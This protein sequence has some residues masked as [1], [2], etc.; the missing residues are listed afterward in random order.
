MLLENNSFPT[1]IRPRREAAAL[2]GDGW[3]VSCISPR[4]SNTHSWQGVF[5]GV[6]VY[7]FPA[8]PELG[9]FLGY[10]V[11][12]GY[13]TFMMTLLTM[14]VLVRHGFD[15][16]HVHNPPDTFF[17][18]G[19]LVRLLGKKFIF[20]HHD[21]SP[22]M[23]DARNEN[24]TGRKDGRPGNPIVRQVLVW[25]EVLTL[26]A[27]NLIIATNGSYKQLEIER[28][29]VPEDRIHIVRNGPDLA[30]FHPVAPD[31]DLR[32]K[33]KTLLGYVGIM[34][35]QD[36]VDYALRALAHLRYTLGREDF[37]AVFIGKGE[38]LAELKK[39]VVELKLEQHVL[40]TGRIAYADL[41][42]YLS[43]VDICLGPDPGNPF[44][45]RS[46]MIKMLEY[47]ALHKPMVAFD[48]VEHRVSAGEAALYAPANDEAA[49]AGLI[50]T[51]MDDPAQRV[52]MGEAGYDRI[53]S[54]LAWPFQAERLLEAYHLLGVHAPQPKPYPQGLRSD[55][56]DPKVP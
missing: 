33:A 21:L 39:L 6:T 31:P 52:R 35:P 2:L 1:D 30:T 44:T 41:L 22:E 12:Y 19:A 55:L 50:Q 45:T 9:G 51:L 24:G 14:W 27:A 11:E 28:S 46:T 43:T 18:L 29:G 23:Y 42:R 16:L 49:M 7:Y 48:L 10:L 3:R 26:R 13:A 40:F 25:C 47:M 32:A 37:F 20:D 54:G 15:V 34:G 17:W 8:P 38:M 53:A 36:G 56:A 5:E 4:P